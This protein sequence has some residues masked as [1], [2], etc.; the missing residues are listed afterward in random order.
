MRLLAASI[1]GLALAASPAHASA[2]DPAGL[3]WTLPAG[4]QPT[5]WQ[6][7][8]LGEPVHRFAAATFALRQ[9]R[10]DPGCSPA[11]A[12]RQLPPDGAIVFMIESRDI[13][14]R[15]LAR[16]PPRPARF[17]LPR[18]RAYACL[19]EGSIVS[20]SEQGRALS[21]HVLLGRRADAARR[22]EVEALL[23]SLVVQWIPPPPPPAGWPTAIS[24]AGDS[25]RVPPGMVRRRAARREGHA[26]AAGPVP[27]ARPRRRGS[28]AGH[29]A[30]ARAGH[31]ARRLPV[32]RLSLLGQ[33]HRWRAGGDQWPLTG[34][35]RGRAGV[36]LRC[37]PRS[38]P[39]RTW[40]R[41]GCGWGGR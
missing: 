32:P 10:P 25:I 13:A 22:R 5:T 34:D 21:A 33:G 28:A 17:D 14:P 29:R 41:G 11:T 40:S 26:A 35:L 31:A 3:A 24:G 37:R 19:G 6:L 20:W 30:P 9:S 16:M 12:R 36:G 23:N 4:W 18:P 2:T 27:A 15:D 7:T 39:C 38:L 8:S 1:A